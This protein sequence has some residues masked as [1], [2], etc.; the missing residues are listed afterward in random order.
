MNWQTLIAD[1]IAAGMT[2]MQISVACGVAQSTV[3]GLARGESK[4]PSYDLGTKLVELHRSRAGTE[5]ACAQ[6]VMQPTN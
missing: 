1:L 5:P 4:S 2:Q 6:P 3:S